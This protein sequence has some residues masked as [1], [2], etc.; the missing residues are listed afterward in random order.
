MNCHNAQAPDTVIMIRPHHF[1]INPE[2]AADNAFQQT[3]DGSVDAT[4]A[5]KAFN[6]VT[7]VSETLKQHGVDVHLFEDTSRLTPDSVF[8]NNWFSTHSD[9]AIA[10]FPMYAPNRRKERRLD[11]IDYLKKHYKVNQI[12]DFS[13]LEQEGIFLEGTGAMVLDRIQRIAYTVASNRAN[14]QALARFCLHFNYQPMLF[15]AADDQQIPIYH[16][17]VLMCVGTRFALIA[18]DLITDPNKRK[19]VE[20]QLVDSER[21]IVNLSAKQISSFCGNAL[22][23]KGKNGNILALSRTAYGAL[24]ELQRQTLA[25]FVTLVPMAI[26]TIELAGGSLRCMLA[27]IHLPRKPSV[28]SDISS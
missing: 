26:P 1:S 12:I 6:E 23:L 7:D 8:P 22:E 25:E 5:S 24:T 28:T 19:L 20:S 11:I 10:L 9:G 13:P 3:L 18:L 17:N 15:E 14:G 27:G 2:T 4:I 16:T 21:T